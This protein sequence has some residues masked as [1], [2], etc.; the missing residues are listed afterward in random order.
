MLRETFART[1]LAAVAFSS[2]MAMWPN[3]ADSQT[4]TITLTA[5]ELLGRLH[6]APET[7]SGYL[8]AKFPHWTTDTKGVSTRTRVVAAENKAN[9]ATRSFR[10]STAPGV[11]G[12]TGQWLSWYDNKQVRCSSALEVDHKVALKEAWDSGANRWST[13]LRTQFANETDLDYVLDAVTSTINQKKSDK[14]PADWVPP[15]AP[16]VCNY[17]QDWLKIKYHWSLNV[18]RREK[19]ALA[20]HLAGQCGA[21]LLVVPPPVI[22][23]APTPPAPASTSP[24][25]PTTVFYV[26][27]DAVR[28]AGKAP[29]LSGQPGYRTKLDGDRDGIACE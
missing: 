24:V 21:R 13:E 9:S 5:K 12:H 29:L 16:R 27:C 1:T 23:N 25:P 18:D 28:A 11:F 6:V 4:K 10:C 20:V 15:Y 17:V 19:E 22:T 8:R 14:D 26:D 7:P 3:S 2:V